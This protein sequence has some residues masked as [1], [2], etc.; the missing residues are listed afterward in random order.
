MYF[1][2]IPLSRYL[3]IFHRPCCL[4][5]CSL[6]AVTF[7]LVYYSS[8]KTIW[9]SSILM[10][11]WFLHS[12][13]LTA[14]FYVCCVVFLEMGP[15][16]AS[17]VT[18]LE[19]LG[20]VPAFSLAEVR[21]LILRQSSEY[22]AE[23]LHTINSEKH[24]PLKDRHQSKFFHYSRLYVSAAISPI[25]LYSPPYGL[26]L[27][28]LPPNEVYCL[29]SGQWHFSTSVVPCEGHH[30]PEGAIRRCYVLWLSSF[31][32]TYLPDSWWQ[33]IYLSF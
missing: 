9:R 5:L 31:E 4:Q 1:F 7:F 17:W 26:L 14:L 16:D 30:T 27:A 28:S 8:S 2:P 25:L 13:V 24:F 11:W 33:K 6:K 18:L 12:Y 22:R 23:T 20:E 32:G 3:G 21:G 10:G 19:C 29:I 15:W